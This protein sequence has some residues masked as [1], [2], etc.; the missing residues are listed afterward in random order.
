MPHIALFEFFAFTI[1]KVL[2]DSSVKREDL[3]ASAKGLKLLERN[4]RSYYSFHSFF[5]QLDMGMIIDNV[6]ES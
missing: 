3:R 4:F 6:A 5:S 2:Q 1:L